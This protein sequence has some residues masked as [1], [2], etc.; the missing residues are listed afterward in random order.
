MCRFLIAHVHSSQILSFLQSSDPIVQEAACGIISQL[1]PTEAGRLHRYNAVDLLLSLMS[2]EIFSSVYVAA[3]KCLE[4]VSC[5]LYL[6]HVL[7]SIF[8]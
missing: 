4:A 8:L 2:G 1:A 6:L 5:F 3:A 7:S